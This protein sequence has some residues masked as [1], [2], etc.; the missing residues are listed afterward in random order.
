MY[1]SSFSKEIWQFFK[2]NEMTKLTWVRIFTRNLQCMYSNLARFWEYLRKIILVLPDVW[3]YLSCYTSRP[4]CFSLILWRGLCGSEFPD[5]RGQVKNELFWKK[6][7]DS[8]SLF[9]SPIP[10]KD[11]IFFTIEFEL[12][13]KIIRYIQQILILDSVSI[14]FVMIK[15]MQVIRYM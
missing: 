15:Y 4:W 12:C 14:F 9:C 11:S 1:L 8:F 5:Q 10:F 13:W 2:L 7:N 6:N 3:D